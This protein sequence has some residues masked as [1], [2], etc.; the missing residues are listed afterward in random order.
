[1]REYMFLK[2]KVKRQIDWNGQ[3]FNFTHTEEDKYHDDTEEVVIPV[4]GVYHQATSYQNKT[5][6]DASVISSKAKP[7]ILCLFEDGSLVKQGDTVNINGQ[8]MIVTGVAN[9]QELNVAVEIS[10]EVNE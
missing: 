9:I 8:D 2:S 4:K 1:M 6:K 5:S 7:M 10:L 3:M